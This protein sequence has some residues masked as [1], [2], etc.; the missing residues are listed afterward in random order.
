MRG[1]LILGAGRSSSALIGYLID[2]APKEQWRVTV[3]DRDL[4][5]A[6]QLVGDV[7]GS[8]EAVQADAGVPEERAGLIAKH[9][10]VISMLPAF[11]HMDVVKDCLRL[12]KHVITPSYVPDALWALHAEV[13][14][15]G[16]IF[17]NELGLDPGIDH[18]SAMRILDRIRREGGRMEAFESYCG[19]L[20]A[21][22]SDTNPWGYKFTW[23]PRNVVLAGQGGMA[24]YIKDGEYKYLPYHRL[25]QQT[26]RVS[27]PGFGEFDGYVNRDSLKYR[28]HY[29]LGEIPTLLRGTLR[30]AG[31]CSAWDAFV[32]LGCTDDSFPLELRPHATWED[33]IDAFLP[34][35][36][37]RDT[38]SNLAHYLALDPKGEELAKLDDLG[39]FSKQRMGVSG[40]SPAATL[41]HLL[42]AK[43]KLEPND[44]D[45]VVMW[46]RFRYTVDDLHQELQ[47][48]LVVLGQDQ[49]HTAMARTVGLP[50]AMAAKAVLNGRISERGVL[51]PLSPEIYEPILDEL[52]EHGVTFRE[53]EVEA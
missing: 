37:E 42:E 13:K 22:E 38:R 53:E 26:V 4:G 27:V 19:G 28:K 20:I 32:Q 39:L 50:V 23:N 34:H 24:R 12:K 52:E 40:L 51:L 21:P 30:K 47:A 25:F 14:D 29:G 48:S 44:K 41:Q 5:H 17:L 15:A 10:L 7:A 3:A 31:F 43:W 36:V 16:L 35:D 1:I 46:H 45:M 11:M 2:H 6:Q 33:F 49:I 18:M 9:D 8:A